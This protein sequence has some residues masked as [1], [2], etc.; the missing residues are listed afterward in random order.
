[1]QSTCFAEEPVTRLSLN[2]ALSKALGTNPNILQSDVTRLS[3]LSNL[4]IAGIT[5]TYGIGSRAAVEHTPGDNE[6]SARAF[7]SIDYENTLGTQ[8][9]A[10]FSPFGLGSERGAIS[11]DIRHPLMSGRGALSKKSDTL[12]G[13]RSDASVQQKQ[14]YL[15]RQATIQGVI[16]SY[17]HAVLAREQVKV[18]EQAV[19]VS[20]ESLNGARK[21]ADAGLVRGIDVSR[22]E[23]QL[24]Q[25]KDQLNLDQQSAQAAVDRLMIAIGSGVGENPD[26]TDDIPDAFS[27]LPGI[28]DAI[29]TALSNRAELSIYDLQLSDQIRKLAISKDTL[30]PKLDV[31]AGLSSS[32]LDQGIISGSILDLSSLRAGI[33]YTFPLDK[34]IDKANVDNATRELALTNR[35]RAFRMEEIAQQVRDAYRGVQTAQTSVNILGQ[36][37]QVAKDNLKMA[38][39]MVDEGLDDNRNVLEAQD[40]LTK[41]ESGL[42]SAK[43]DLYLA[44]IN[45]KLAMGEDLAAVGL[46]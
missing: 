17:F 18:S 26:L 40:S 29:K 3:S 31:V 8:A 33:E 11:I 15:T 5:T 32:E 22:A 9:T 46:K 7:G 20:E 10:S 6:F 43:A 27:D 19:S 13:A 21:R 44:G 24:A 2:D 42:L 14:L 23:I 36:N 16:E 12:A 45:L 4:K 30:K 25:T 35:L 41:V 1:M 39:R 37:V 28:A 38:Q 34:R